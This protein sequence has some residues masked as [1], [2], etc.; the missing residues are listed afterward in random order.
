ME[1]MHT[2]KGVGSNPWYTSTK[3]GIALGV[4]VTRKWPLQLSHRAYGSRKQ[5]HPNVSCLSALVSPCSLACSKTPVRKGR[6]HAMESKSHI[7]PRPKADRV[8]AKATCVQDSQTTLTPYATSREIGT[9]EVRTHP[10][11]S[12]LPPGKMHD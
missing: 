11:V 8:Q 2:Q 4:T 9:E 10:L 7:M 3:V 6:P 12:S 1:L 5:V